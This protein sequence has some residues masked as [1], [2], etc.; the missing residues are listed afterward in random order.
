[1]DLSVII[2]TLNEERHIRRCI[3]SVRPLARE[4]FVVDCFSVDGTEAAGRGTGAEIRVVT[5]EWPGSQA[6]Q[7][8]WALEN[9]PIASGWVLRLDAD[10]YLTPELCEEIRVRLPALPEDVS[11]VAF[12]LRRVFL[13][14]QIRHGIPK[15]KLLRLFRRGKGRCE[16]RLMDEHVE[17]LEGR[18]V[19]FQG[20]FADHNL[21]DIGW[22]TAKHNGYA[23]RE[24]VALLDLEYGLLDHETNEKTRKGHIGAQAAAKRAKKLRYARLPLFWRAF[25]YFGYRY[26]VRGGFLEGREGFLW[27]FLQGWWY[28]TL[29]DA[30]VWE[31]TRA[32]GGDPARMREILRDTYG[33]RM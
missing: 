10:E 26:F 9:L 29:V 20:E 18:S 15:I 28:R 7:F 16:Q 14:R 4:I 3:E 33:V 11:G 32:S 1:M 31:I 27:H 17:L 22:W 12:N 30:K 5:R 24:A 23:L 6:E 19:E 25:V 21:N 13:G 8:N 2:L